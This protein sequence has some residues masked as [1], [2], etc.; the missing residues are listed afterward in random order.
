VTKLKNQNHKS[1]IE[2][3]GHEESFIFVPPTTNWC[4]AECGREEHRTKKNDLVPNK[5]WPQD[6]QGIIDFCSVDESHYIKR[7]DSYTSMEIQ[8]LAAEFTGLSTATPTIDRIE[9]WRGYLKFIKP[10]ED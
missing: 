5:D 10:R 9:V 3:L 6:L 7:A 1:Y 8:W 4:V 2:V